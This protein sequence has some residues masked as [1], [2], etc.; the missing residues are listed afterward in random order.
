MSML[1]LYVCKHI[2]RPKMPT[3][4]IIY[5]N[6]L[7]TSKIYL[8]VHDMMPLSWTLQ[9]ILSFNG[10]VSINSTMLSILGDGSQIIRYNFINFIQSS[11]FP[12][13]LSTVMAENLSHSE[14]LGGYIHNV[15]PV[16]H[17]EYFEFQIQAETENV[18]AACFSPRKRTQFATYD[19]NKSPFR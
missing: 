8:K 19:H 16:Y 13:F 14:T 10:L 15:S 1:A 7:A 9:C 17:D 18:R 11:Y 4:S 2:A 5:C 12:F 3:T 6:C